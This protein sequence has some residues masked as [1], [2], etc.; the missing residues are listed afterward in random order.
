MEWTPDLTCLQYW[1]GGSLPEESPKMRL[2]DRRMNPLDHVA[3]A[4]RLFVDQGRP[5]CPACFDRGDPAI[6]AGGGSSCVAIDSAGKLRRHVATFPVQPAAVIGN[7][8]P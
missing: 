5:E 8:C 6:V 3:S 4:H 2:T 7:E 1:T